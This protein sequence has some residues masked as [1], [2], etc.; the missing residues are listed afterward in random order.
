MVQCPCELDSQGSG[1]KSLLGTPE[2]TLP[3]SVYANAVHTITISG[4]P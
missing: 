3:G 4:T 1:E 2:G